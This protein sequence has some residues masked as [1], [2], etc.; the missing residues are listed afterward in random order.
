MKRINGCPCQL[1][2]VWLVGATGRR[3]EGGRREKLAY[4][5]PMTSLL[6][7]RGC[8][9]ALCLATAPAS[10]PT[11]CFS[12]HW[13]PAT[14]LPS[15]NPLGSGWLRVFPLLL[16]FFNHAC[17]LIKVSSVELCEWS[18]VS[19]WDSEGPFQLQGTGDFSSFPLVTNP[20]VIAQI[21]ITWF[22]L[23]YLYSGVTYVQQT[24]SIEGTIG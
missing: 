15:L 16:G 10:S 11:L 14:L 9:S 5:F 13:V 4:F 7:G 17:L 12:S 24:A 1:A 8:G 22:L 23:T 2:P 20:R 18:S 19:C 6:C 21:P 3:W